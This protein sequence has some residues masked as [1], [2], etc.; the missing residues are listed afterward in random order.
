MMV[1]PAA[2]AVTPPALLMLAI[3]A[4]LLLHTPPVVVAVKVLVV[5]LH[6]LVGPDIVPALGAGLTVILA[7]VVAVPQ[8][9]VTV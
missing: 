3:D 7:V 5:D 9:L 8:P 4:L 2:I 6:I 1:V